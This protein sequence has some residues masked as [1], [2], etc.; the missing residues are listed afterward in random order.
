MEGCAGSLSGAHQVA[1]LGAGAARNARSSAQN[2]GN[3]VREERPICLGDQRAGDGFENQAGFQHTEIAGSDP[4]GDAGD[5]SPDARRV[6]ISYSAATGVLRA[7]RQTPAVR[8]PPVR[9]ES[10]YPQ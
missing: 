1:W 6:E 7:A 3:A 5:V 2:S 9:E 4:P 10:R 8:A